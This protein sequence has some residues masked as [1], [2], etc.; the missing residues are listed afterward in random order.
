[1]NSDEIKRQKENLAVEAAGFVEAFTRF[2][3]EMA[4]TIYKAC[5]LLQDF[6]E[7]AKCA[8]D[9][10]I[11]IQRAKK[12]RSRWQKKKNMCKKYMP[13]CKKLRPCARSSI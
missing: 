2:A 12:E 7:I 11:Q 4:E 9:A 13:P 6:L 10:E 5:E 3:E 8:A 1:M